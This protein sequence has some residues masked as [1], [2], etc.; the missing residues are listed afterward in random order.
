MALLP[1]QEVQCEAPGGGRSHHRC[2]DLTQNVTE[3][4]DVFIVLIQFL[5]WDVGCRVR[6]AHG[7]VRGG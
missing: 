5:P 7:N 2:W 4:T 1:H 3:L 6:A